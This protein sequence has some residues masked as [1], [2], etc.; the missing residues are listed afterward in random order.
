MWR[1]K[2]NGGV[3]SWTHITRPVN[4]RGGTGP[5]T[6]ISLSRSS[7]LFLISSSFSF[8][9]HLSSSSASFFLRSSS[10]FSFSFLSS[11]SISA[12]I[13]AAASRCFCHFYIFL[14]LLFGCHT[15]I[16]HSPRVRVARLS[17]A[18]TP[19][20]NLEIPGGPRAI[21]LTSAGLLATGTAYPSPLRHYQASEP[22]MEVLKH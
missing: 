2:Y 5:T 11:S 21:I 4:G 17:R 13:F 8:C 14:S 9:F 12:L 1:A 16:A 15:D 22:T 6:T 3:S 19:G 7:S 20:M 18:S 10:S